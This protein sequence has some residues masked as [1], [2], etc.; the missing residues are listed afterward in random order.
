M[1]VLSAATPL[2]SVTVPR[3]TLVVASKKVTVPVGVP[4]PGALAVTVAVMVTVCPMEPLVVE[5]V[6]AVVLAS[7]LIVSVPAI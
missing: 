7:L 2:E 6:A 4:E 5:A 3:E 1:V